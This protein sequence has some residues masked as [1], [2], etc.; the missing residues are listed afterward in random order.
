MECRL[1]GGSN[2]ETDHPGSGTA[3]PFRQQIAI[4]QA[5]SGRIDHQQIIWQVPHVAQERTSSWL[6]PCPRT[7][8]HRGSRFES[9]SQGRLPGAP[10]L[11]IRSSSSSVRDER[12][13][14]RR[15]GST[16]EGS[17]RRK[18]APSNPDRIIIG[19][20]PVI[21][22]TARRGTQ[23]F[24]PEGDLI[25]RSSVPVPRSDAVNELVGTGARQQRNNVGAVRT[26]VGS[27]RVSTTKAYAANWGRREMTESRC[28]TQ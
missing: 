21:A 17:H 19:F 11:G 18:A 1:L 23:I 6:A 26:R 12:S 9:A 13:E 5:G 14:L 4:S 16:P 2:R 15:S 10:T 8:P 22:T 20:V 24:C 28:V 7:R 27:A 3:E 25:L